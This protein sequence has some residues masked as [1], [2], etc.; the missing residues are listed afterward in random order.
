MTEGG[1]AAD[2]TARFPGLFARGYVD[3]ANADVDFFVGEPPD[4]LIARIHCIATDSAGRVIVCRSEQEWRFL[5]GGTREPDE[6]IAETVARELLEEAGAKVT[7]E[8]VIFAAQVA[9]SRNEG[10]YRPHMPHPLS[11]WAFALTT[12]DLI[13]PPTNPADGEHVVEVLAL[14]VDEAVRW[15]AVHDQTAA[16]VVR[17]AAAMGLLT[18][19]N[20]S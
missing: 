14:P 13:H 20:G 1:G 19:P 6:P 16:D 5:P 7:G 18:S 2:W 12:A 15:L 3:Y 11:Y 9:T 17:L 8:P 10:P 4:E